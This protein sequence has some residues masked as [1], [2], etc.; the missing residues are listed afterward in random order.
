VVRSR[1]VGP[2]RPRRG[3]RGP[4]RAERCRAWCELPPS[5]GPSVALFGWLACRLP[6]RRWH[7][8]PDPGVEGILGLPLLVKPPHRPV[9]V[10]DPVPDHST[11][12]RLRRPPAERGLN[13]GACSPGPTG[14][15]RPRSH[16]WGKAAPSQ[17]P[18]SRSPTHAASGRTG[19]SEQDA[20]RNGVPEDGR[21]P[22]HEANRRRARAWSWHAGR[23][24][25]SPAVPDGDTG[26]RP[27]PGRRGSP[28]VGGDCY[29]DRQLR[30]MAL[31]RLPMIT[32]A[33]GRSL[34][35]GTSTR[36]TKV[37]NNAAPV[38]ASTFTAANM[39]SSARVTMS[40]P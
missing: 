33:S 35:A 37:G 16:S 21:V 10:R 36:S 12:S 22:G 23:S 27:R 1:G 40:C 14:G 11:L 20:A 32:M 13:G 31:T 15:S 38:A 34:S 9:A 19:R 7:R 30:A 3:P 8:Q 5:A 18:R 28:V 4:A 25:P 17:A 39:P 2:A 6:P 29:S 26:A 24:S